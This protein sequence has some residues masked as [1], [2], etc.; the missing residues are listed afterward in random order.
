M[1]VHGIFTESQK[2]TEWLNPQLEQ[3]AISAKQQNYPFYVQLYT[4]QQYQAGTMHAT[5]LRHIPRPSTAA[6][7][8]T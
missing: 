4:Q 2:K 6:V 7:A 8:D 3:T 5:R 1:V